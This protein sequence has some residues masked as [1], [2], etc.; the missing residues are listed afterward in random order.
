MRTIVV[1]RSKYGHTRGYAEWLAE[2]L[3]AELAD[4][5]APPASL[6]DYDVAVLLAPIYM[7][8]L[9][10]IDPFLELAAA[11]PNTALVGAT[12]CGGDPSTPGGRGACET[13]IAKA[14][15][16]PMQDRF[17]WFH[18]RGGMDYPGMGLVDRVVMGFVT[19]KLNRSARKRGATPPSVLE[20]LRS[21]V[22]FRDRASLDPLIAH[23]RSL[24][25]AER[26][27]RP[28]RPAAAEPWRRR[29]RIWPFGIPFA[30]VGT[31]HL[32]ATAL[33]AG[34]AAD[35]TQMLVM[36][37]L[38]PLLLAPHEAPNR[39]WSRVRGWAAVA[40]VGSWLGD[41][42]PRLVAEPWQFIALVVPFWFAQIGW[43][44]ALLPRLR[45]SIWQ[46]QRWRLALYGVAAVAVLALTLPNAGG[47]APLVVMYAAVLAGMAT[48][49]TGWGALGTIGGWL[50]LISDAMI[51][52]FRFRP[53]LDP[54]DPPRS[55]LVM[56]TYL[57]AQALLVVGA[58]R[59]QHRERTPLTAAAP[60]VTVR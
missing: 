52:V 44:A 60:A 54:G 46:A 22:D 31:A 37:S 5:A 2:S 42:L 21:R 24:A 18:L 48:A 34:S 13:A 58:R 59:W 19:A 56:S 29:R 51:A 33:G 49:A 26:P 30:A 38:L 45:Q 27:A 57:A 20:T 28:A 17:T 40:L 12:V 36:P 47:F 35:L 50:F 43:I 4:L 1:Y 25:D 3:G 10:G 15:P 6:A 39:D 8:A 55:L 14:V 11:A 23:V 32:A 7:T 16:P 9:P 41:T 53:E